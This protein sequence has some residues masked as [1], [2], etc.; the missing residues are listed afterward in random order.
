MV[1]LYT[2]STD[3]L[4]YHKQ[5]SNSIHSMWKRYMEIVSS[6]NYL[7][8]MTVSTSNW[9]L[10]V[11]R[12]YTSENLGGKAAT[13]KN[14]NKD[15]NN[16]SIYMNIQRIDSGFYIFLSWKL[17][18]RVIKKRFLRNCIKKLYN[19]WKPHSFVGKYG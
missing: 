14:K 19:D 11:I 2:Y 4:H 3:S 9:K 17:S 1:L 10:F 18:P 15:Y 6:I 16:M 5:K 7:G 8:K 13:F 12:P